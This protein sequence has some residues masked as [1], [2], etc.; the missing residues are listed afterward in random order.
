VLRRTV[1]GIIVALTLGVTPATAKTAET[2]PAATTSTSDMAG[3]PSEPECVPL[4]AGT[5][6]VLLVGGSVPSSDQLTGQPGGLAEPVVG[7]L[8]RRLPDRI[9]FKDDHN[10]FGRE[11]AFALRGGRI[12]VRPATVGVGNRGEPWRR[13]ELPACLDG[14]VQAISADHRLLVALGP[15]R[16][17]YSHDMPGGDL[18]AERW[19]WRW[20]PYFWTGSGLR[21][22]DDVREWSTSELTS[23]EWFR[24]TAGREHHPIGVATLYLLRGDGRRITY[25]DPW[26]PQD[27]SREVCGPRRGTMPLAGLSGSGSTL[28]VVG[29][30]GELYT[31]LYDFDVSG[32]NTVFGDYTW[33]RGV[34][35][36]DP[37]WQ[38]PGPGWLRQP[39]PPGQVTDRISI[40][41]TGD[42]A[43]DRSLHVEGRDRTGHR[44]YWEKSITAK[45]WSFVRTGDALQG[46]LLPDR[47]GVRLAA[48]DHRYVGTVG[49]RRAVVTDFNAECSPARLRV[50]VSRHH[51]LDLLLH[52]SDGLRQERRGRGLTDVPREYNGALEVPRRTWRDL[53]RQPL[54]VRRWV[55]EHL[56]GR[57]TTAPLEVTSTRVRF[58]AQC[59]QLT[60]NGQPARDPEP[61]L[62]PDGGVV[63]GRLTEM[64]DDGRHPRVCTY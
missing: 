2:A 50:R 9:V 59:W 15:D 31:R 14:H 49:G 64:Q 26:L 1:A 39:H 4:G 24:D 6:G 40:A 16:Q 60:L 48:D 17:V 37:R 42:D 62:P 25:L 19:T 10:T 34:P 38:L 27:E 11:Y 5:T 30:R 58:L 36:D 3:P 43:A 54:V 22:F 53:E 23:A 63:V 55:D 33:E 46:D 20:G 32:A 28:F 51:R 8:A 44:G 35:A 41:K 29:E 12:Y 61:G 56:D 13:L 57:F 52:S 21:M 7:D 45:R 18:S 47:P